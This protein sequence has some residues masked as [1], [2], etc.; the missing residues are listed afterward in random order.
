M[1]N[2]ENLST[3][4][5]KKKSWSILVPSGVRLRTPLSPT[6]SKN[7]SAA[8][9]SQVEPAHVTRSPWSVSS[10]SRSAGSLNTPALPSPPDALRRSGWCGKNKCHKPRWICGS[11]GQHSIWTHL[12][13][14]F[15]QASQRICPTSIRI[16]LQQKCFSPTPKRDERTPTSF[17][18]TSP[19][20]PRVEE[21]SF[22]KLYE[23][24]R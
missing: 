23:T 19:K 3:Q 9:P 16:V 17:A 8:L 13:D 1:G 21:K 4:E 22:M 18:T 24:L 20:I 7:I 12:E 15:Y 14:V 6:Q 2:R 10:G 5:E 11:L